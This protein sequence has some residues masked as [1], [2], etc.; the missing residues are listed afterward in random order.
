[1]RDFHIKE[2]W[3]WALM[4]PLV[5][6]ITAGVWFYSDVTMKKHEKTTTENVR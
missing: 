1:M 2:R 3:W 5:I 4:V 6:Y